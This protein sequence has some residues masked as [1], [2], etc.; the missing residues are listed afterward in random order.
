[1]KKEKIKIKGTRYKYIIN[2]SNQIEV[3]GIVS[4]EIIDIIKERLTKKGI[5]KTEEKKDCSKERFQKWSLVEL[6]IYLEELEDKTKKKTITQDE[7]SLVE[8][9]KEEIERR[10]EMKR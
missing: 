2:S 7:I 5:L 9:I 10:K 4:N 3:D 1:M 8:P 6:K